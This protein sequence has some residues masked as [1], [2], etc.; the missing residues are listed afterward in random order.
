MYVCMLA[1]MYDRIIGYRHN[2]SK[3]LDMNIMSEYYQLHAYM[4][5]RTSIHVDAP[6]THAHTHTYTYTRTHTHT[7][8]VAK[9]QWIVQGFLLRFCLNV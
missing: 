5:M 2:I 7:P 6:Y 9:G 3:E 8:V 4:H 1:C